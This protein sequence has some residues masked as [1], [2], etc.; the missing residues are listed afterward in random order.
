MIDR[1]SKTWR[2]YGT[3]HNAS[4]DSST[5]SDPSAEPS[6]RAGHTSPLSRGHPRPHCPDPCHDS[7]ASPA[8]ADTPT[9][10]SPA[11]APTHASPPAHPE[12]PAHHCGHPTACEGEHP[13]RVCGPAWPLVGSFPS[14]AS[15]HPRPS[16]EACRSQSPVLASASW[17]AWL[18][19]QDTCGVFGGTV[20][21]LNQHSLEAAALLTPR[22]HNRV[23]SQG[24]LPRLLL[25]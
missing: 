8:T 19:S 18:D 14:S 20:L 6:A 11:T 2:L 21:C 23:I 5:D 25:S 4:I 22:S 16:C 17:R 3:K 15:L 13:V 7:G 12:P 24:L 9:G 10:A 1:D